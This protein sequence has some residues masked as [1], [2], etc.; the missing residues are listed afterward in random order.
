M[1]S[2]NLLN[3]KIAEKIGDFEEK[4]FIDEVDHDYCYR[5]RRKANYS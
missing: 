3:L 2:G 4:L 5:I 1:T